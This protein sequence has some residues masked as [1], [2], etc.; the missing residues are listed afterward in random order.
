MGIHFK[1]AA[2]LAAVCLTTS[3]GGAAIAA[4][5]AWPGEI[6]FAEAYNRI[7]GTE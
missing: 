1:G 5:W 3:F 2:A 7:N 4:D 6:S